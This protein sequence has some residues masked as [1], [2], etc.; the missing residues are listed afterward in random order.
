M[1]HTV[2]QL[3]GSF[4]QGG[5]ERQAV[6]LARSLNESGR[7][8]V[9]VAALDGAGVLR[10]EV[11]EM[12]LS[13]EI[14]SFPLTSFYNR[15]M[16]RQL[17]RFAD[18]VKRERVQVVHT[19]DFYSNIFGITGAR[20]AGV[21]ARIA[22]RR[23]T[24]GVRSA[25]QRQIER[26]VFRFA[27]RIVANAEAVRNE[28]IAEGTPARKVVTVYNGLDFAQG[29]TQST[30]KAAAKRRVIEAWRASGVVANEFVSVD[31][32][33]DDELRNIGFDDDDFPARFTRAPIV[34]IVANMRLRVKDHPTFLRM[35]RR[36]RERIP[37]AMFVLAGEGE[38]LGEL[39]ALAVEYGL[40]HHAIFTGR[41]AN[42]GEVLAASDVCVLSSTGEGFSNSI[43]E[44]MAARRAVVATDVGGVREVL[45]DGETGIIVSV[46]DDAMMARRVCELLENP[47]RASEMGER[48]RHAVE[49]KFSAVAQL[50]RIE[51]LY[52]ELT[53]G[54]LRAQSYIEARE[55][56]L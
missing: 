23:E 50:A 51:N 46:G 36:V 32:A 48:G 47:Q 7:Y 28:V 14:E 31:A 34:T 16:Q 42:V 49:E 25:R 19:H 13:A 24:S 21:K 44:Y 9:L 1:K 43:L 27:N 38:L 5:S 20:L 8:R 56:V 41:C 4:H 55:A 15:G 54:A 39:R 3:I 30:D 37:E 45:A 52:D 29:S 12:N 53:G 35:A 2:L 40:A 11:E 26:F 10:R 18:F 17:K 33:S 6:R 22:S